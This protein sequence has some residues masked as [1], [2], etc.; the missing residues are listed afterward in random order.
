VRRGH[1]RDRD[2]HDGHPE[3]VAYE[4]WANDYGL[5][6]FGDSAPKPIYDF[7]CGNI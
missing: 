5:D 6:V 4:L 3:L 2:D 7:N 1:A